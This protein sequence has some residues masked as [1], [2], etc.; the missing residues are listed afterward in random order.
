MKPE[1]PADRRPNDEPYYIDSLCPVCGHRLE[2]LDEDSGWYDEFVCPN[3]DDGIHMDWPE[4]SLQW[5]K[6]A[7]NK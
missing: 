1:R 3:C 6:E 5:L 4:E 2:Y 7:S